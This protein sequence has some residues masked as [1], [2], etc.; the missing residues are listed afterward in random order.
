MYGSSKDS[1]LI[2]LDVNKKLEKYR[3][4]IEK[5]GI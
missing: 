5:M 4:Y 3:S 1:L 2:T